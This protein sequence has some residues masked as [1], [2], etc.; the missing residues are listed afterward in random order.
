MIP[1]LT[2]LEIFHP[3]RHFRRIFFRD[4]FRPEVVSDIVSGAAVEQ[5]GTYV[6]VKCGDSKLSR[7]R[8]ISPAYVLC[9]G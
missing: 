1:A 9:D 8:D 5:V 4:N 7:S 6:S 3:K 2:V